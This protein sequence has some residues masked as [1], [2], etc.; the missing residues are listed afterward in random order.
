ME[1]GLIDVDGFHY[2]PWIKLLEF[3][4]F[5]GTNKIGFHYA[6]WIKL[7]EWNGNRLD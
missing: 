1:I 2:A 7:L 4:G 5:T 3:E 6:P